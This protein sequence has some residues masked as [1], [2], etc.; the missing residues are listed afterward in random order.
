MEAL[1][2]QAAAES[3]RRVDSIQA[4]SRGE[5]SRRCARA[6]LQASYLITQHQRTLALEQAFAHLE[7]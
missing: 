7:G 6:L 5:R 4:D 3:L 2:L 1:G